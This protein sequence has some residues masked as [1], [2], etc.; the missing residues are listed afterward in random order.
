MPFPETGEGLWEK[1]YCGV[2]FVVEDVHV[3]CGQLGTW[4]RRPEERSGLM[5]K[6]AVN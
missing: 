6:E 5:G 1:R 4:I 2:G 3:L